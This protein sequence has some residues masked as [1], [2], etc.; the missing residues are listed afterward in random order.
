MCDLLSCHCQ[1]Y[2]SFR[3]KLSVSLRMSCGVGAELA[4]PIGPARSAKSSCA[5]AHDSTHLD[6]F[7][8]RYDLAGFPKMV[9]LRGRFD[10]NDGVE[11][12]DLFA[13][14]SLAV[15]Q[16]HPQTPCQDAQ[17]YRPVHLRHSRRALQSTMLTE[18]AALQ[19]VLL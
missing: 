9:K 6:T 1:L 16:M 10:E 7:V 12:S 5:K 8:Y 14:L 11:M 4:C 13:H 18:R 2:T 17:L 15:R 3:S 19:N